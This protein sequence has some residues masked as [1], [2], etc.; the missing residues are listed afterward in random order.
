[1]KKFFKWTGITVLVLFIL[2]LIAPF[3]FKGKIEAAIKQAANDNI[4][5]KV[6]WSG[7]RL[8]LIRNFP[9]LRVTIEDLTI[10]NIAPFDSV[11][12]A[13]IGSLEAVV[14][15]KSVFGDEIQV[16]RIGIV[17]PVFDVRITAEGLANY[18][19]AKAD[20]AVV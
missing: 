20:S 1:M 4:N 8:S 10:D 5:G 6:N 15:I 14:D 12:L 3:L 18:D 2:L 16:K 17:K 7:V 13:K 9:N 19:I 11:R